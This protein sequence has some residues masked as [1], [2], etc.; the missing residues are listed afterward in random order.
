M[1]ITRS[2]ASSAAGTRW[3]VVDTGSFPFRMCLG[4]WASCLP[5]PVPGLSVRLGAYLDVKPV[6]EPVRDICMPGSMS[7][8]EKQ[9]DGLLG[10]R[11]NER[12]CAL[13]APA[14]LYATALLLDSTDDAVVPNRRDGA[15]RSQARGTRLPHKPV[16]PGTGYG[17]HAS[18]YAGVF[19]ARSG[20]TWAEG[21][22]VR[23]P[24]LRPTLL[25]RAI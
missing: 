18:E 24:P 10:E 11:S 3:P 4:R 22:L 17:Y 19:G 7:G 25:K 2:V 21:L 12:R 20:V 23:E 9:S 5:N 13:L 6:R 14:V 8:E 16:S 15:L 1:C